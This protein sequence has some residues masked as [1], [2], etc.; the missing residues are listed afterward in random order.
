MHESTVSSHH[1]YLY[2]LKAKYNHNHIHELVLL[3]VM[4]PIMR[5]WDS[6]NKA[7]LSREREYF[8]FHKLMSSLQND[9]ARNSIL[10]RK[11]FSTRVR[12]LVLLRRRYNWN[13]VPSAR[14]LPDSIAHRHSFLA[15]Q[16]CHWCYFHDEPN[17]TIYCQSFHKGHPPVR[18]F[19]MFAIRTSWIATGE[20]KVHLTA[21]QSFH[22][23]GLAFKFLTICYPFGMRHYVK[24]LSWRWL[25]PC[26]EWKFI[27]CFFIT[28][29]RPKMHTRFNKKL[30]TTTNE[31][32]VAI[33][34]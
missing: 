6:V 1:V 7:Y 23:A 30:F 3:L 15:F 24:T 26:S 16:N 5:K 32:N 4:I 10:T 22:V 18:N 19:D 33:L 17:V 27:L 28:Q 11:Y 34:I 14:V 2:K 9:W 25:N 31:N 12:L 29:K 21:Y 8:L 20:G 13:E